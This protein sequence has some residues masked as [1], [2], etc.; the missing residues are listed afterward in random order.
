MRP[1]LIEVPYSHLFRGLRLRTWSEGHAPQKDADVILVFGDGSST[2]AKLHYGRESL[3]AL[4]VAA[5]TTVAGTFI[6]ERVWR[7]KEITEDNG[8]LVIH[9]G[10]RIR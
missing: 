3:S 5:Y 7:V 10:H 6:S 2:T 1:L 4:W 8:E 9:L